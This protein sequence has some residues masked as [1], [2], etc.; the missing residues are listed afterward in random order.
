MRPSFDDAADS[1]ERSR[2]AA[3]FYKHYQGAMRRLR[4]HPSPRF[5]L[6]C[7]PYSVFLEHE[8][9]RV[10][11]RNRRDIAIHL[12]PPTVSHMPL[13]RIFVLIFIVYTGLLPRHA[14][15]AQS[16]HT[17]DISGTAVD[18]SG[19]K[20]LEFVNATL[21]G[22][23]SA[24]VRGMVTGANGA[25]KFDGIREGRYRVELRL[26]GYRTRMIP[27]VVDGK[28]ARLNL[29]AVAMSAAP[30]NMD[31]VVVTGE[32]ALMSGAIDRKVYNMDQD[33]MAKAGSVSELLQNVPSVQVDVEGNVTL[34]G[35]GNV[36]FMLNG[37]T[38]PLLER[39]AAEVLQQM[40][41]NAIERIEVITNPSAKY[42][43]D[44]TAGIINIVQKK[45][46][47]LGLN[48][49][50]TANAGNQDR[51]NAN[52]RL[53]YDPGWI[54]LFGSYALRRDTRNRITSDTR[55]IT[56]ET[57]GAQSL[58]DD[59]RSAAGRPLSHM[60]SLGADLRPGEA[61]RAGVS[62]S[63]FYNDISRSE[64]SRRLTS[65]A[66]GNAI[67]S[68]QRRSSDSEFEKELGGKAYYEHR[69]PGEEHQL[70]FEA[71]TS[72][73]TESENNNYTNDYFVPLNPREREHLAMDE[74][75]RESQVSLDYTNS[76]S[77]NASL[78]AGYAGQFNG[79]ELEN[80]VSRFDDA[81]QQFIPDPT[82]SNHFKYDGAIHALYGTYRQAFGRFGIQGGLRAEQ[83]Y[84]TSHLLTLDS[85]VDNNYFSLYPTLHLSFKAS[86]ALEL[87]LSYSR[88]TNRPDPDELNPFPEYRDPRNLMAGNPLLLPE[89][90]HSVELSARFDHPS[91]SVTP[92]LY[93]RYTYNRFTSVTRMLNDST[94]LTTEENLATDRAGG[95]ECIVSANIGELV[96][97]HVSAN[98]FYNEIDA[99]NLGY[100]DRKSIF[101][102][103]GALT[104]TAHLTA[105]T[106]LQ[107]NANYNA[108]RLTP[109]GTIAP[110]AVVN[111][112]LRQE[113][114]DGKLALVFTVSDVFK[115][116]RRRVELA[117]PF[118]AQIVTN[119][120]DSRVFFLG[121]TW[122]FGMPPKKA[123][124]EQ[125]RFD[126]SM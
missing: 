41:A 99:S 85:L 58:Y 64:I 116:M 49:N 1:D 87:G 67:E 32:K 72:S 7:M 126:E 121:F 37:K 35:S 50:I 66:A 16:G 55:T 74:S 113:L 15:L 44:G 53:N 125:M 118:L 95:M 123:K 47:M 124:E 77:V 108:S 46:A 91:F 57:S 22:A 112:G 73:S 43:P 102:W 23:D 86:D 36:T 103:S 100:A 70:R 5:P 17:S 94:F 59:Q 52:G 18:S 106:R 40:P 69:F 14:A 98:G 83:A 31:E 68:Y 115:T 107:I 105:A 75:G 25:F 104:A 93:Y 101:S 109:Q 119:T 80:A 78:E 19:M 61:D 48:G 38:T 13:V 62:G 76:F 6:P 92:S 81:V 114:F 42:K 24:V 51:Y 28:T 33:V 120:R 30:V 79:Y 26:I 111:T 97:A 82:Q 9:P 10:Q 84:L 60:A 45:N 29:G 12:F 27:V 122:Y 11:R 90:V 65:D 8:V 56:D 89:Y 96:T 34:R 2:L 117:T 21:R 3:E 4:F 20:P 110:R 63:Y 39:N 71:E 88:R 54:N